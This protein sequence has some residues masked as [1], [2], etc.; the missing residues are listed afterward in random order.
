MKS[1]FNPVDKLTLIHTNETA[2]VRRI[3][4]GMIYVDLEGDEIPVYEEDVKL[5]QAGSRK[6][7]FEQRP[8]SPQQPRYPFNKPKQ[9]VPVEKIVSLENGLSLVMEPYTNPEQKPALTLFIHNGFGFAVHFNIL[10]DFADGSSL[11]HEGLLAP[12]TKKQLFSFDEDKLN[13][14]PNIYLSSWKEKDNINE[15]EIR[16]RATSHFKKKRKF[17]GFDNEVFVYEI[18]MEW[19]G[20]RT[21]MERH[22]ISKEELR[23]LMQSNKVANYDNAD[24]QNGGVEEIDLHAAALGIIEKDFSPGE[25][26]EKQLTAFRRVLERSIQKKRERLI[27]IHGYGKGKLKNEV[28]NILDDYYSF[29]PYRNEYHHRY[30]HGATFIDL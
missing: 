11:T 17:S 24:L 6:P 26:L 15:T 18:F 1:Q 16:L 28:C 12:K 22:H 27:V 3:A 7:Q 4:N 14:K 9:Q 5:L 8:S 29:L 21:E 23:A 30:G 20:R 13:E 25:I 19:P 10:L 2:T